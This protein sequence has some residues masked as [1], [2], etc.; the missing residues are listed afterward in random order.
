MC[1][2][3]ELFEG[4]I[5]DEC[6][7]KIC[8]MVIERPVR[9]GSGIT[10]CRDC[11][12]VTNGRTCCKTHTFPYNVKD[13]R[14]ASPE[15]EAA[16]KALTPKCIFKV[17]GCQKKD[18]ISEDHLNKEKMADDLAQ[19]IMNSSPIANYHKRMVAAKVIAQKAHKKATEELAKKTAEFD[20]SLAGRE[21]EIADL[22]AEVAEHKV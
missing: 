2:D 22:K 5:P 15:I 14:K 8:D 11:A 17:V 21:K 16:L 9:C 13:F 6:I 1:I 3:V 4:T 10:F 20:L 7:C 18:S 19:V 12:S